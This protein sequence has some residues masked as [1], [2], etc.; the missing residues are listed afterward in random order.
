LLKNPKR[1]LITKIINENPTT[2]TFWVKEIGDNIISRKSK[3]GQ[4][5]M[6]WVWKPDLTKKSAEAQDN[7]PMS[8]SDCDGDKFAMTVKKMGAT[9]AELFKY[10]KGMELGITGPLGN[11]FKLKGKRILLVSGGI[12]LAPLYPLG[13]LAKS[14]GLEV[15]TILGAKTKSEHLMVNPVRKFSKKVYITTDDGSYGS[16][17]FATDAMD[18]IFNK[19]KIDQI[20][21]CGPEIMMLKILEKS[22][23]NKIPAQFSL[24]RYMHCGVGACGLC[25]MDG[26]W[27]CN[28][29]PVFTSS[30]LKNVKDFGCR[31][32][33]PD[34]RYRKV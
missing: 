14:K 28:D 22:L 21:T 23:Y 33:L 18:K 5:V 26:Y 34:G 4:Y 3:P 9:T 29:G 30:Q 31:C 27:I 20:Y 8:V 16:K 32:R 7:I 25:T 1:V 19:A 11:A 2:K 15:H 24:E 6:I 13:K 12:G 17:G 10:K